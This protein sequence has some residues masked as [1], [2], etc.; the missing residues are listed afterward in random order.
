MLF[1]FLEY[2]IWS[3]IHYIT[4]CP[5][6]I[7]ITVCPGSSDPFY[8]VTY[9]LNW[10]LPLGQTVLYKMGQYFLDIQYY[11]PDDG[12]DLK[13]CRFEGKRGEKH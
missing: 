1:F 6:A 11:G 8:L 12:S 4:S 5:L 7:I 3:L 10:V 2:A 9:H 13:K